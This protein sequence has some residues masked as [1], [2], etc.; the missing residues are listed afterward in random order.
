M[1]RNLCVY[2]SSSSAIAPEYAEAARE[3]GAA[4]VA[5][6]WD[7]VYGGTNVGLMGAI[8]DAVLAA[9]GR[10]TGVIPG[11]ISQ[12]GIAHQGLHELIETPNMR[13]RKAGMDEL[14]DAFLALPGGFGTLEEIFEV[15]TSKQLQVHQRPIVFLN[16][17]NFYAPLRTFLDHL[18]AERFAKPE[19]VELYHFA[20][21]PQEALAHLETYEPTTAGTKWF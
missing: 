21:T 8:A 15:V 18:I 11:H 1:S 20:D 12:R 14:A 4:M 17:R 19:S 9:G 7:L 16:T 6:G 2:C 5:S 13:E 10:A 3:L